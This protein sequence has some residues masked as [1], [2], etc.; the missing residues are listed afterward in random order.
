MNLVWPKTKSMGFLLLL[1]FLLFALPTLSSSQYEYVRNTM[2][3]NHRKILPKQEPLTSYAVIFD[4][5]SSGS[6]VHVF[7]FDQ[8]LDLLHIGNDLEFSKK[9]KPAES[10]VPEELHPKT[11]LKL[12]SVLVTTQLLAYGND[13]ARAEIFKVTD[14]A[15]SPCLL[16]GYEESANNMWVFLVVQR[17]IY[18]YSGETYKVYG[19]TSGSN[20]DDREMVVQVLR[21]NEPCSH[22][23]CTFGGIWDGGKG[24]G[25]KNLVVTSSFYYRT[26]EV[27]FVT[28][29]N[30]KSR[31]VEWEVAAKQA[32]EA[33]SSLPKFNRLIGGVKVK[34]SIFVFL[35][36]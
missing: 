12:G 17:Y 21:L 7:H 32:F 9:I 16:A 34:Q 11:P 1:T 5:G 15:A 27:G 35:R 24:S 3:L 2:F 6:R 33:I 25:Q 28:A 10:V 30:S 29:P 8:N 13:A 36:Y 4:A 19:P 31:P 22:Q 20:F 14:G 23:N 18:K 26:S